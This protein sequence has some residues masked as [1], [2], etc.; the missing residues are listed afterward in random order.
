MSK[1]WNEISTKILADLPKHQNLVLGFFLAVSL[2]LG[3][4]L[5]LGQLLAEG[6]LHLPFGSKYQSYQA[7]GLPLSQEATVA[8]VSS[9]RSKSVQINLNSASFLELD[10]LPGVGP[11]SAQKII[12]NRPYQSIGE[13]LTKKVISLKTYNLIKDRIGIQ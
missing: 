4:G 5:L 7:K 3:T 13:L 6:N 8:A 2:S 1:N 11:T 9:S 10:S 12:S